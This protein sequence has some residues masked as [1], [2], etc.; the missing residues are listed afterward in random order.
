[1]HG[2]DEGGCEGF[3]MV[4]VIVMIDRISISEVKDPLDELSM[5]QQARAVEWFA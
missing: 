5:L 4:H 1:M 3:A 2:F